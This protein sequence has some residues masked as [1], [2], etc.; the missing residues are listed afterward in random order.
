MKYMG[1]VKKYDLRS[2][3]NYIKVEK[4]IYFWMLEILKEN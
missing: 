3:K 2:L 1:V 4:K